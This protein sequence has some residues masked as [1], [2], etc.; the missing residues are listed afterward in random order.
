LMTQFYS[1]MK[2]NFLHQFKSLEQVAGKFDKISNLNKQ[3]LLSTFKK[4]D[5]PGKKNILQ[6]HDLLIFICA[7]PGDTLTKQLAEEELKR[8][9]A[10]GKQHALNEIHPENEG[11]PFTNT[12]TRFSPDFLNWLIQHNDLEVEFDS[13]YNPTL[14]L[15]D[16]LNITLPATLKAETTAGLN[17]TDLLEVLHIKPGQYVPFLLGQL[18]Q[19]NDQP[20]L[21]ELFIERMD[22]YVKLVPKNVFFSRA[23]NRLPVQ[24]IYFHQDLLKQFD[25]NHLLNSPL[26]A[27]RIPKKDERLELCKVIKNSMALTVREIDPATFLKEDT[28]R[29]YDLER[30]LTFAIYSMI[31]ERQLPLET[32]FGFTFF[33]NGF[34]VS[35]GGIWVF[36]C[37]GKIGLNVFEPFRSGESGYVL[38]QL[39]RVLKQT[40]GVSYVE[41]EPYQFGLDNPGGIT[42][43]A[44]W[45][46]YKYGFRPVD[47]ELKQ[48]AKIEYAKIKSRKNYRS[49]SK[50][51][52]QFTES[53]IAL[54]LG[55]K[56]PLNVLTVTTK[57]LKHIKKE[58]HHNYQSAKQQAVEKFCKKV[59]LE[60]NT[61]SNTERN[62]LEDLAL[63]AVSMKINTA[64]QL[65][66]MKQ[67]VVT[68]TKDD[69]AYQQL[70]LDFFQS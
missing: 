34:P 16:I 37:M 9:T 32:Y 41:I 52:L 19:L 50:T 68:K 58:W 65:Q 22:L 4:T 64:D 8:I 47:P 30:G 7:Y 21:K 28:I 26:N 51:L 39:L 35:Y 23:Y 56:I 3:D 44:F 6:Y 70:L 31:A 60:A 54:N 17:N 53:N 43:G 57:V 5:L 10:F 67:M 36:G 66:L 2:N 13:F 18:E 55:K 63:W 49:S 45:F 46:Y 25:Y 20:L 33:K 24:K 29:L 1:I 59:Q 61:L 15:N 27:A 69:Y 38:C 42:S 62:I 48:L 14:S 12:T 11:L 40:L